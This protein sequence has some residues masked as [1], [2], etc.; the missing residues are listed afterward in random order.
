MFAPSQTVC[1]MN[2]YLCM[3]TLLG[4]IYLPRVV[5]MFRWKL[6]WLFF[7]SPT[8][9]KHMYWIFLASYTCI[10]MIFLLSHLPCMHIPLLFLF[11][12]TFWK[13]SGHQ[14]LAFDYNRGDSSPHPPLPNRNKFS[15][16]LLTVCTFLYYS[17]MF[18]L[19]FVT[20]LYFRT[21]INKHPC[22][23]QPFGKKLFPSSKPLCIWLLHSTFLEQRC[24]W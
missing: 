15:C 23:M 16:Q 5:I 4:G 10:K 9:M 8:V 3:H 12:R 18:I 24:L 2:I 22:H 6:N 19:Y 1:L 7:T 17:L 20:L 21:V 14:L 11:S 13:F